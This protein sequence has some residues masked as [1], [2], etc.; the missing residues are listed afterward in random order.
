MSNYTKICKSNLWL[1]CVVCCVQQILVSGEEGLIK[2]DS[3]ISAAKSRTT[4]AASRKVSGKSKAKKKRSSDSDNARC[5]ESSQTLDQTHA[6]LCDNILECSNTVVSDNCSSIQNND[7]DQCDLPNVNRCSSDIS[8]SGVYGESVVL[9]QYSDVDKILVVDNICNA[10]EFSSSQRILKEINLFCSDVKIDFAY[11]LAKGGV[12]IHTQSKEDRNR[13]LNVL[14]AESF[15]GGVKHPPLGRGEHVAYIKG[16]D[17]SVDVQ[18]LASLFLDKGIELSYIRRLTQRFTGK[19]IQVVRV[20]CTEN[21]FGK[22]LNTKLVINNNTCV[23]EKE[24]LV[25]VIRC[26][27]CQ[28]FGHIARFC[29]NVVKCEF[30]AEGHNIHVTCARDVHCAN[31]GGHHPA[32]SSSCPAYIKRYEI[33]ATQHTEYLHLPTSAKACCGET[34]N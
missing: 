28:R 7:G 2:V 17:T 3:I 12:A 13:L 5:C 15:G 11:S 9:S 26:Y 32:S 18:K 1:K 25:K 24:R 10:A 16:V 33:I 31:C 19:P 4:G 27:N 6:N 8:D 29:T 14:P 20:K 30:C 21:S 23:I 34:S 22:L